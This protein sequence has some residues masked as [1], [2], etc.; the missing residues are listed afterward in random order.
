MQKPFCFSR[1]ILSA[2]NML[3][4]FGIFLVNFTIP[5]IAGTMVSWKHLN[6]LFSR[7]PSLVSVLDENL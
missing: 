2:I 7:N 5:S 3:E 4:K 6:M 1:R